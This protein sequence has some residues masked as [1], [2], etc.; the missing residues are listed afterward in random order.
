MKTRTLRVLALML[1]L[2]LMLCMIPMVFAQEDYAATVNGV[3]YTTVAEAVSKANG[4]VV[5]LL[6]D[7]DEQVTAKGDLYLDLNGHNLKGLTMESGKLY[8]MDSTTDDYDCTDGYGMIG[9]LVGQY[10]ANYKTS[11]TGSIRRYLAVEEDG[12]YS[13]HRLY[14][15][16]VYATIRPEGKGVG[17]KAIFA[18]DSKVKA[19]LDTTEAFGY[20]LQLEGSQP[21]SVWKSA[22]QF[23]ALQTV[24]LLVKDFDAAAHG[25]T[26]LTATVQVKLNNGTVITTD[27]YTT[28]LKANM[29][30]VNDTYTSYTEE[31]IGLLADWINE[32]PVMKDW[33]TENIV[34]KEEVVP[35]GL[36]IKAQNVTVDKGT[37]EVTVDVMVYNNPGI[38]TATVTVEVDDDVI[39]F[40]KGSKTEFP[41]LYLTSP[42]SKQK[43]SPYNFL[44]DGMELTDEDKV[45]GTLF[46]ITFTIKDTTVTGTYDIALSYV[47][48]DITDE[49]YEPL[50]VTMINGSITIK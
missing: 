37:G 5:K 44:L 25:Q 7:S 46:T 6:K 16:L 30:T 23:K 19:E 32:V 27:A 40:K 47:D 41:G 39:G 49:N 17:Y 50:D 24:T 12:I 35:T 43:E 42:G 4:N 3:S 13:F 20:T 18:G 34:P 33:R 45:D 14:L 31:Q 36:T 29:E 8:G 38:M 11:V 1:T 26:P 28:T 21:L 10:E 48:G 9:N 22:S 15:G 2:A